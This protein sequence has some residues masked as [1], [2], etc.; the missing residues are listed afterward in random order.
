MN[1]IVVT[2]KTMKDESKVRLK[3]R[4][5]YTY[6]VIPVPRQIS[7]TCG[8]AHRIPKDDKLKYIYE[9]INNLINSGEIENGHVNFY[10]EYDNNLYEK[11]NIF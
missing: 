3:I 9:I 2:Y 6:E 10:Y 1:N 7:V 11:Y 8:I 4:D 5:K